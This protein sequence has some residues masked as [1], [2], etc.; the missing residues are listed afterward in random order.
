M[1]LATYLGSIH[2]RAAGRSS[3]GITGEI[4]TQ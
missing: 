1:L 3:K 2:L 4:G